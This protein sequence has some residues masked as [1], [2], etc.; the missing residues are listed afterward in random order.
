MTTEYETCLGWYLKIFTFTLAIALGTV[1]VS[2]QKKDSVNVGTAKGLLRDSTHNYVMQATTVS[3]YKV[4]TGELVSYQLSDNFGRFLFRQLPVDIPLRIIATNIGYGPVK[5]EFRISQSTKTFDLKALNMDRLT[6]SLKEVVVSGAPPPVQMRG[7]TL[8][9]NAG[10]FKLDTNAVVEDMLRRLP[11]VTIWNDGVITVNGK[12][13][14]RL[15]VEGK[16]FFGADNKIALQNLPKNAVKKIQVYQDKSEPDPIE[17]KTNMNIVLKK[18]KKDGYFGKV[19]GGIGTTGRYDDNGMLSYY[20]P[21]NQVSMV[22][23]LNNVNKTADNTNTLVS[24]NSFKGE[25]ISNDYHTDFTKPGATVFKAAGFS[26]I[27]DFSHR[28]DNKPDTNRLKVN[29]FLAVGNNTVDQNIHTQIPLEDNGYL[30]QTTVNSSKFNYN[31]QAFSARY[32]KV[33]DHGLLNA[34]YDFQH[35][36]SSMLN[37]RSSTSIGN[38][39]TDQ[40]YSYDEQGGNKATIFHAGSIK[41]TSHRYTDFGTNRN[42]SV[43]MELSYLFSVNNTN[44]ENRRITDFNA[45]DYSQDKHFNR[46]YLTASNNID[47]LII[48]SFNNILG[49]LQKDPYLRT[50]IKNTLSYSERNQT[51]AVSDLLTAGS[52]YLPNA[53]LSNHL[54]NRIINYRPGINLSK[55]IINALANRFRKTWNLSI[56]TEGQLFRQQNTAALQIQN[57]ERNYFYFIP[58]AMIGYSNNQLGKFRKTYFLKY[59]TTVTYPTL[60]QLAPL[61][62]DANVYFL[63]YG[64]IKLRPAYMHDLSF[65][66][67]YSTV[68]AKNPLQGDFNVTVGQTNDF[69]TDSSYYDALGR[70][71]YYPINVSG[72]KHASLGGYLQKAFKYK[73]H[74]FQVSGKSRF[75]YAQYPSNLNGINYDTKTNSWLLTADLIY[76]YKGLLTAQVGESFLG[77]NTSRI[78]IAQYKYVNWK[79]YSNIS[80]ALPKSVFFSTRMDFNK[81]ISSNSN[82]IYYTIWNI[83]VGYRFLKGAN[84]EIKLSGLDLF[85]QNRNVINY[86]N[87]NSITTGTVNVLQQYFMV[88]LAYY[89]R[90]FGLSKV[91]H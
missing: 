88:T 39:A 71:V 14:N 18:D 85:H 42:R 50:D 3:I 4:E 72:E 83:D 49:V 77:N 82:N 25:G 34:S 17:T 32:D 9:F 89:P 65:K 73:D 41:F 87:N 48:S 86:M 90:K 64:N 36:T 45:A 22:G 7:D 23:A 59:N 79:T 1:K 5:R 76:T 2:A 16:E 75:N 30:N 56:F 57:L 84:G 21:K 66:Y 29:Y 44:E 27:H 6:V 51:D 60:Q 38:L 35:N 46:R 33:F 20:S 11:G 70:S 47:H 68:E 24:L 74:Q 15:L 61:V 58:S 26:G 63:N 62:D 55:V 91:E 81:N 69:I 80:F 13:I 8:E 28:D 12:K 67:E 19:S 54:N 40:S 53:N 10:A 37:V 31:G 52:Q 43:E 78:G